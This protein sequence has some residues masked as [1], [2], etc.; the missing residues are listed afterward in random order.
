MKKKYFI[1]NVEDEKNESL[2][3]YP[4]AAIRT[5]GPYYERESSSESITIEKLLPEKLEF[6]VEKKCILTDVL[7]HDKSI[8]GSGILLRD[9]IFDII[10]KYN[11]Q[12]GLNVVDTVV[13][14]KEK[15][16]TCYK[17]LHL[18]YNYQN[19]INFDLTEFEI[20]DII[21]ETRFNTK[22]KD[23]KG[24]VSKR[25]SISTLKKL[26]PLDDVI[27]MNGDINHLDFFLFSLNQ[28][29]FYLSARLAEELK[30]NGYS[31]FE[32]YDAGCFFET[33]GA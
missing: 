12:D 1:L 7:S 11:V 18:G 31:G 20:Y 10:K 25:L 27:Y 17:Y 3:C 16:I 8:L 21:D 26:T 33:V 30:S 2:Y 22:I 23:L 4:Q 14:Y 32:V 19:E 29:F 9:K 13:F 15:E 5:R 6:T 28:P 24:L